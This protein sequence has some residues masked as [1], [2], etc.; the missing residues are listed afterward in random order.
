MSDTRKCLTQNLVIAPKKFSYVVQKLREYCLGKGLVESHPQNRLSILAACED[1]GTIA[2]VDYAG[3]KWPLPQTGQMWLEYDLLKNPDVPGLFC[4]TTSYRNEPKPVPGRHDLVF[5]MFEFEIRGGFDKLVEF[6]EGL[7]THMG[8]DPSKFKYGDYVDVAEKYKTYEVEHEH[9]QKLYEEEGSVFFL[10]HFPRHTQPFWNMK[11]TED[12][13]MAY[14]LDVIVNGMETVGSAERSCNVKQMKH[15]FETISNGMYAK[16][17]YSKIDKESVES[18]LEDYLSLENLHHL[19]RSGGGIGLTRL[20]KGMETEG[21]LPDS[22]L[23][24][25]SNSVTQQQ[26]TSKVVE[27]TSVTV[28]AG[29]TTSV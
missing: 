7:L 28:A 19:V 14:K 3:Y 15:D 29:V 26:T 8:Y 11:K 6:C 2:T 4:V 21:L 27:S 13:S 23:L 25:G 22:V 20:I 9:E 18:E 12:G 1:P 24:S 17:L 5:P 10:Q 16:T